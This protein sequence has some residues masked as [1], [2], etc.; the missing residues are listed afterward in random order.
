MST[1]ECSLQS[2]G[3]ALRG[4]DAALEKDANVHKTLSRNGFLAD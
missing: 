3:V 4:G 2:D 1:P